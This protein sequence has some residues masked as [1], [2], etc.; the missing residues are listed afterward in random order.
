MSHLAHLPLCHNIGDPNVFRHFCWWY[1]MSSS[2]QSQTEHN[3][4]PR[5]PALPTVAL[6]F[7]PICRAFLYSPCLGVKRQHVSFKMQSGVS[8]CCLSLI[9]V[10]KWHEKQQ[11]PLRGVTSVCLWRK[12][13]LQIH[14]AFLQRQERKRKQR[15]EGGGCHCGRTST[16]NCSERPRQV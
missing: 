13:H 16:F 7:F 1:C 4:C 15:L 9:Q 12:K 11:P 14:P 2:S 5:L 10:F 8:A 6:N 3:I